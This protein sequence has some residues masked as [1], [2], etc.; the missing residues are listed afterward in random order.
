MG[1]LPLLLFYTELHV[2]TSLLGS[3]PPAQR[4][5]V[6]GPRGGVPRDIVV[7]NYAVG[8]SPREVR[9]K[10]ELALFPYTTCF[11]RRFL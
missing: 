10:S 8:H 7:Q 9:E 3:E 2:A 6:E 4:R 5:L 1:Y 11:V